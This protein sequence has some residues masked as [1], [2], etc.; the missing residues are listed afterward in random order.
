M[1]A[2]VKC[3]V[4]DDRETHFRLRPVQKLDE[5]TG[6][7]VDI[8]GDRLIY[9]IQWSWL[10]DPL[11]TVSPQVVYQIKSALLKGKHVPSDKNPKKFNKQQAKTQLEKETFILDI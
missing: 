3:E 6:N 4:V 7:F 2:I 9:H 5:S 1:I 8:V 10:V 11:S